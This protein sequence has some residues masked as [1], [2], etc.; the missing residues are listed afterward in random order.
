MPLVPA[1]EA[2]GGEGAAASLVAGFGREA[3]TPWR[4]DHK[5]AAGAALSVLGRRM[6][7]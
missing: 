2:M 3:G 7:P 6:H 4:K 5:R 1:A